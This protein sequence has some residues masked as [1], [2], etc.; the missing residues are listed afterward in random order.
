LKGAVTRG[1][2][3]LE[4]EGTVTGKKK[5]NPIGRRLSQFGPSIVELKK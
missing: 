2:E 3:E 4:L 1:L 5:R